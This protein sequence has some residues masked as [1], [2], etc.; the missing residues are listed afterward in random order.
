MHGSSPWPG[1]DRFGELVALWRGTGILPVRPRAILALGRQDLD[2]QYGRATHGRDV[3]ATFCGH[4][5]TNSP[6]REI[7]WRRRRPLVESAAGDGDNRTV[8]VP[9]PAPTQRAGLK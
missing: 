3:H 9:P 6:F 8:K 4:N 5:A 1:N 7:D 2:G